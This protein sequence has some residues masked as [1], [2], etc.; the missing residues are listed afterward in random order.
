MTKRIVLI[1]AFL[2]FGLAVACSNGLT[3]NTTNAPNTNATTGKT[4]VPSATTPGSSTATSTT[5]CQTDDLAAGH[6]LY[7]KNCA[8][9]H[10]E[11]GEGGPTVVDGR[12][13]KPD[14]LTDDRRKKLSDD[15]YVKTM[16]DGIEDEGMPSFKDKMS[17]AE[18]REVVKYI[19]VALQKQSG[20][21]AS[22]TNSA[23]STAAPTNK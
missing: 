17:E 22:T 5:S 8:N 4:P 16:V 11:S 18:M 21:S 20:S 7:V 3:A 23:N 9:C 13:M 10:K 1:T 2:S 14:N 15:K 19:R 6:D 12:K